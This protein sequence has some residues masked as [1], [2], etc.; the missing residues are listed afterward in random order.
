MKKQPNVRS[1]IK[2]SLAMQVITKLIAFVSV[3]FVARMLT[4]DELG[5]FAIVSAFTII[6]V[7]LRFFGAGNY[8]IKEKYVTEEKKRTV[9]GVSLF[10]SFSLGFLLL[11]AAPSLAR[12]FAYDDMTALFQIMSVS[13]FVAP[14]YLVPH[15]IMM[16]EYNF[17]YLLLIECTSNLITLITTILLIHFGYSYYSLAI[18]MNV[19]IVCNLFFTL[20]LARKYMVFVPSL[21]K[22]KDVINFGGFISLSIIFERLSTVA[23]DI[24]IGKLGTTRDVAMYS[25]SVGFLDFIA[26]VLT[27]GFKP[28]ALPYLSKSIHDNENVNSAYLRATNLLGSICWPILSVAI[29]SAYPLIMLLFGEQWKEAVPLVPFLGLWMLFRLIHTL[30]PSLFVASNRYKLLFYKS[31]TMFILTATSITL[32]YEYGLLAVAKAMS[33]VGILDFV[34]TTIILRHFF[35]LDIIVMLGSMLRN[36]V[37]TFI[38]VAS[39]LLLKLFVDIESIKPIVSLSFIALINIPIWLI[40][41]RILK[42]EIYKEFKRALK[43]SSSVK[44]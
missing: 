33:F 18:S 12:F 8:L 7:D 16:K 15:S 38:A 14:F 23:P 44:F 29:L 10:M 41:I 27:M 21:K 30:S 36:F 39:T 31:L 43:L 2:L 19:T 26:Q 42:L 28:V 40:S 13:F 6:A 22:C 20:V 11:I 17:K 4:P 24:I 25:R 1:A 35:H 5:V 37:L 34:I 3:V 32:S 9:L